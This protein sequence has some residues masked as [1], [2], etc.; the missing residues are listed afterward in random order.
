MCKKN[1]FEAWCSRKIVVSH[2]RVFSCLA[3]ESISSR[4]CKAPVPRPCTFIG[5]QENAKA[6]RLMDP[7][8]HEIFLEKD[9]HFEECSPSLSSTPLRTSYTVETDSDTSDSASTSSDMWG[10]V[11]SCIERSH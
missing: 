2:F 9:V 10:F 7:K 1:P 4:A 5:Y 6:Y 3:W 8:T 11:D